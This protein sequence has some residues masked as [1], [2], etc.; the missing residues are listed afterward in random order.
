MNARR[1]GTTAGAALALLAALQLV[2]PERVNP[3]T[4]RSAHLETQTAVPPAVA[5]LLRRACY[6][7]HSDETRWPWYSRVAPA[8]W[9]VVRDVARGRGQ[10]NFSRWRDYHA[11]DRADLLDEACRLARRREMPMRAYV[12]AHAE[13]RLTDADLAM[14]CAWTTNEAQ[15]LTGE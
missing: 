9:L 11:Y 13:A 1:V 4:A 10:L 2:G 6:D 8:S 12:L 3:A 5:G 7:C 15:R 14:L